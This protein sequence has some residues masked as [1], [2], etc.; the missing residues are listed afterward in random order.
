V[1]LADLW[2]NTRAYC[3]LPSLAA[4]CA[5]M[6]RANKESLKQ[7]DETGWTLASDGWTDT[8]HR[9]SMNVIF[10]TPQGSHFMGV[11]AAG[12]QTKDT[13]YIVNVLMKPLEK[14]GEK[15]VCIVTDSAAVCKAAG[16]ASLQLLRLRAVC[17]AAIHMPQS[18][19]CMIRSDAG[20]Q[21]ETMYSWVTWM[22]CAAHALD[23]VMKDFSKEESIAEAFRK[24]RAVVRWV[25]AHHKPHA[26]YQA[27]A[28]KKKTELALLLPGATRFGSNLIMTDRF[29]EVRPALKHMVKSTEWRDYVC[30]LPAKKRVAAKLVARLIEDGQLKDELKRI[31]AMLEPVRAVLRQF[32]GGTSVMGHVYPTMQGLRETV[33]NIPDSDPCKERLLNIV[34]ERW[35]FMHSPMHAAAYA[36][37]PLYI[38]VVADICDDQ[39]LMTG[40]TAVI[41]KLAPSIDSASAALLEFGSVYRNEVGSI[42]SQVALSSIAMKG[43]DPVSWWRTYG[44]SA[45]HLRPIAVKVLSQC[46]FASDC[47][48]NWSEYAFI[49]SKARNRLSLARAEQLVFVHG[50]HR[51]LEEQRIDKDKWIEWQEDEDVAVELEH[52]NDGDSASDNSSEDASDS[53]DAVDNKP[54]C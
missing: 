54:G 9:P 8:A 37:N 38:N 12:E 16:A 51:V 34:D 20:R 19:S 22:P 28:K 21:L 42:G 10:V 3:V 23:L 52:E 17:N 24:C 26:L 7:Q 2:C 43:S 50:N 14:Y 1:L 27:S 44:H 46:P 47:E 11:H 35:E 39:E 53:D 32:D 31:R 49:H 6:G 18:C 41:E 4:T 5:C 33:S 25:R 30:K 15:I 13:D 45:K 36:I 48:R 29:L 40:L